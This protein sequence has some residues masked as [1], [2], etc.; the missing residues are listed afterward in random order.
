[1]NQ[2]VHIVPV[3]AN[4]QNGVWLIVDHSRTGKAQQKLEEKRSSADA[5]MDDE[6]N[7][8]TKAEAERYCRKWLNHF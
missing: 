5:E 4:L 7:N 2:T 1:M 3:L 6:I 8:V